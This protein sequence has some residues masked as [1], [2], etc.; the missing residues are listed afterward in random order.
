MTGAARQPGKR[1]SAAA[2]AKVISLDEYRRTR[3]LRAAGVPAARRSRARRPRFVVQLHEAGTRYYEFRLEADGVLKS[4]AVPR[5]PSTDPREKRL[6][7]AAQDHPIDGADAGSAAGSGAL[8]AGQAEVWDR[9]YYLNRSLGKQGESIEVRRA[10]DSGHL[11]IELH[12]S[13]LRG[14]YSLIR[15]AGRP[16]GQWLLVKDADENRPGATGGSKRVG[17]GP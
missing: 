3:Q 12:G 8:A 9:G 2:R 4:W 11:S 10:L 1:P 13:K 16:E 17:K 14:N 5:G 6:A 15:M 7:V